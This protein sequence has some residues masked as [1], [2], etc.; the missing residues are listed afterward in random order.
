MDR[1][2]SRGNSLCAWQVRLK[3]GILLVMIAVSVIVGNKF[4]LA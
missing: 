1:T 4:A 2:T 3:F